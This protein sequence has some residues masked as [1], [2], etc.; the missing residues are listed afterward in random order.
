MLYSRKAPLHGVL[1]E[2]YA[3]SRKLTLVKTKPATELQALASDYQAHQRAGRWSPRTAALNANV[4]D[5]TF[6]RWCADN[7]VTRPD[8]LNQRVI[9]RWTAYLLEDHQTPTGHGLARESVRTYTRTLGSFI[10]WAQEEGAVT[11]KVKSRQPTRERKLVETL[12]RQ[13]IQKLEDTATTARDALIIRLLA[14]SGIRLGELLGLRA[15]DLVEQ[16]RERFIHVKGKGARERLV[17]VVP[18]LFTR[19]KRYAG[20]SGDRI[21]MTVR[22]SP[23]TGQLER[24]RP[25]SVQNMIG[26][27]AQAAGVRAT[28]PHTFR[29]SF[30]TWC[31]QPPRSMNPVT[32]AKILGHK[33]LRMIVEVYAHLIA[34]DTYNALIEV[35]RADDED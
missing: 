32:L 21:F 30:A 12:T 34:A 35:M 13:E 20:H 6:L 29:H 9:D 2:D 7:E 31:L 28:H 27:V 11:G 14:D 17:P 5:K 22:R 24:L 3:M 4:L 1:V 18:A 15:S 8:Q 33:D 25:R 19:L 16:G 26:F 23:K 10:K